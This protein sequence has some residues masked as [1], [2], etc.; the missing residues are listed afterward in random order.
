MARRQRRRDPD[1]VR[2]WRRIVQHWRRSGLSVREF[3]DWQEL[4]EP[5]FY[6]WRRE[7]CQ[8][9]GEAPGV[10]AIVK[11]G[12]RQAERNDMAAE[13]K[14]RFLPLEIVAEPQSATVSL[15]PGTDGI[16]VHLP[17][18][19][20]L[21]VPARYDRQALIDVLSALEMRPC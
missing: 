8:H 16:E 6:F 21:H 10:R 11:S 20:R 13:E 18:G 19:V 4:S 2:H 7:L 5:S 14:P 9:D 15:Q 3:C 17:C 1:K 12:H